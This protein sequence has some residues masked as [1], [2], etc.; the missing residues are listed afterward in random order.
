MDVYDSGLCNC[1]SSPLPTLTDEF[2]GLGCPLDFQELQGVFFKP[3]Q[4]SIGTKRKGYNFRKNHKPAFCQQNLYHEAVMI[5]P[6]S[7]FGLAA[8]LAQFID[9]T[10][11]ILSESREIYRSASG[12]SKETVDLESTSTVLKELSERLSSSSLPSER[13]LSK[14]SSALLSALH[15]NRQGDPSGSWRWPPDALVSDCS[16]QEAA[17]RQMAEACQGVATE[18]LLDIQAV[19]VS[20]TNRKRKWESFRHAIKTQWSSKRLESLQRKMNDLRSQMTLQVSEI[21]L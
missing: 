9:F 21:I 19:N 6:I 16:K 7:A 1:G 5:D 17:L 18:I 15:D 14:R 3:I 4:V 13:P 12:S 20:D 2:S 8:N 11:K 10:F